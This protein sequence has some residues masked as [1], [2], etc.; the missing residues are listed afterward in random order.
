MEECGVGL[1]LE[2]D[3]DIDGVT[4]SVLGCFRVW[5]WIPEVVVGLLRRAEISV[6]HGG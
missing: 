3:R 4:Y 1:W 2:R 5:N 6:V